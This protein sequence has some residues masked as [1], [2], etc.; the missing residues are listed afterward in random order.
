MCATKNAP[1]NTFRVLECRHGLAEIVECGAVGLAEQAKIL[2]DEAEENNLDDKVKTER[3]VRWEHC[4]LCEQDYHGVVRCALGW[5]CWKTYVGRSETDWVRSMAM[6]QLGNGLSAAEQYEDALSVREAELSTL[7]RLDAD[8]DNILIAQNNLANMYQALGRE[9][10]AIRMRQEVYAGRLELLGAEH[11]QTVSAACNY[12]YSLVRLDRYQEARSL[13]RKTLP[14]ARRVLGAS[15]DHT[16][17]LRLN[18]AHALYR[19]PGATLENIR[20]AGTMFEDI[21]GI[22]RRVYSVTHPLT[23]RIEHYLRNVRRYL[24]AR[25]EAAPDD[26][27]SVCEEMAAM[28]PPGDA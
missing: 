20:A 26:V 21:E 27:S 17:R 19:D 8:E 10:L 28:T 22:V 1:R 18:Y 6:S 13:L 23:G 2:M 15:H 4:S 24:R 5:A 11:S 3:W 16:L 14:V 25:E 9:Q 12:A 7:R